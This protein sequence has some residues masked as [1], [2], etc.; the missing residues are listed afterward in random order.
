MHRLPLAPEGLVY[1]L[2][3]LVC[4][5]ILFLIWPWLALAGAVLTL[6]VTFFFRNPRRSGPEM[7]D[8]IL[9]PAD[10]RVM[11]ITALDYDEFIQ[12]PAVRIIIFLSLFNVHINRAPMSGTVDWRQYR[13]GRYL[14]AFKSHASDI[15]ERNSI[16]IRQGSR[17]IVVHQITGFIARRIVCDVRPG[18]LL[19]QRQRFGMIRFGS[20]T[21]LVLPA[22]LP[23][24]VQPGCRVKGGMTVLA[25]FT[26]DHEVLH[27]AQESA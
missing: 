18:D 5:A 20:G 25:Q 23:V 13:P 2:A 27:A 10:G 3:G 8:A 4:T 19:A 26:P 21:E 14:P 24:A 1:I 15:N 7:P 22:G 9:S 6:F 11:A 16:G 17:R 12:G